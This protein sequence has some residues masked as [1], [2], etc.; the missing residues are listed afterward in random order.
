MKTILLPTD[1]SENARH[2]ARFA[3]LLAQAL[4]ARLVLLHTY[5][6]YVPLTGE[7]PSMI[8]ELI[9]QKEAKAR[10]DLA[11]FRHELAGQTGFPA[12]RIDVRVGEGPVGRSIVEMARNQDAAYLV[13]GTQGAR[14]T[15]EK[16]LGTVTQSVVLNA[17]CPVWVVPVQAPVAAPRRILYAADLERDEAAAVQEVLDFARLFGAETRVLHLH[18]YYEL[19]V[20]ELLDDLRTRFRDQPVEFRNLNR[21]DVIEALD[22]YSKR[23]FQP[24]LLA[25]AVYE[26]SFWEGFLEDSVTKHFVQ[27]SERPLLIVRKGD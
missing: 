9:A 22:T 13:M 7:E 27:T 3:V 15:L 26:K 23:T 17:P 11:D 16:W 18:E 10:Q 1:F 24:D 2:A 12:D 25:L 19:P 5:D 6:F 20:G 14:R 8:A 4:P 21:D